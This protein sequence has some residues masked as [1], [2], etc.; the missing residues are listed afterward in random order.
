MELIRDTVVGHAL[1]LVSGGKILPYAE[2]K[3]PNLWKRYVDRE[4]TA[5]MAHHGHTGPEEADGDDAN[6]PRDSQTAIR[7]TPTTASS[8][9]EDVPR[10]A[11]GDRIDQEKG[12]DINVVHW[13]GDNDPEVR[14]CP[15]IFGVGLTDA[16]ESYELV[17]A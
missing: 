11:V 4:K 7:R 6:S 8:R 13:Y 2:D 5:D 10:N 14:F 12:R 9:D 3:D 16:V 17:A 15:I 1:R